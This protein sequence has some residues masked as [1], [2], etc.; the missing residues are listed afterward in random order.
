MGLFDRWTKPEAATPKPA[1]EMAPEDVKEK[2]PSPD[3]KIVEPT[4]EVAPTNEGLALKW[5]EAKQANLSRA[6]ALFDKANNYFRETAE[7]TGTRK[8]DKGS[9]HYKVWETAKE[10]IV[11]TEMLILLNSTLE[12]SRQELNTLTSDSLALFDDTDNE[13]ERAGKIG[14]QIKRSIEL[15]KEISFGE[16]HVREM[17][18]DYNETELELSKLEAETEDR[19]DSTEQNMWNK[20]SAAY[21]QLLAAEDA[22]ADLKTGFLARW[23]K[24]SE[25]TDAK[26][27]VAEAEAAVAEVT[28]LMDES[29]LLRG[30]VN[31]SGRVDNM[32]SRNKKAASSAGYAKKA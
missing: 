17:E 3:L 24:A 6:S 22:L 15:R 4:E 26:K 30:H 1:E 14:A 31:A 23:K 16:K 7:S 29:G 18:D 25:I 28:S 19:F 13:A 5:A 10:Q 32:K 21:K 9:P 2:A 27:K 8:W 11:N 20:S 12:N